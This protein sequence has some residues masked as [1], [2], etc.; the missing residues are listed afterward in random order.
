MQTRCELKIPSWEDVRYD[1]SP[2][3]ER[4]LVSS[5]GPHVQALDSATPLCCGRMGPIYCYSSQQPC[6]YAAPRNAHRSFSSLWAELRYPWRL[7]RV[8]GNL[9][10]RLQKKILENQHPYLLCVIFEPWNRETTWYWCHKAS[11][12]LFNLIYHQW[13]SVS[14]DKSVYSVCD[15]RLLMLLYGCRQ[16]YLD[17]QLRQKLVF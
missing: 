13:C 15:S 9:N 7:D 12:Y 10:S 14:S 11:R 8:P 16:A 5:R 17:R 6:L 3:D 2:N 1:V 4:W